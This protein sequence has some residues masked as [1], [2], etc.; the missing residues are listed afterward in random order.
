MIYKIYGYKPH[1]FEVKDEY[2]YLEVRDKLYTPSAWSFDFENVYNKSKPVN[3]NKKLNSNNAQSNNHI[4]TLNE[5]KLKMLQKMIYKINYKLHKCPV[6]EHKLMDFVNVVPISENNGISF[7]GKFCA[8]CDSF[9]DDSGFNI[10]KTIERNIFVKEYIVKY[11]YYIP[12]Y[13]DWKYKFSQLKSFVC[14]AFLKETETQDYR[15][16]TIVKSRKRSRF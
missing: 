4:R 2:S 11:D 12:E 15:C 10:E 3:V 9:Y 5:D 6:Y 16:I 14:A 8:L 7:R 13:N 1:S